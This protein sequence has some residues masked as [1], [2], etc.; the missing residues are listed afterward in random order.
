MNPKASI[1]DCVIPSGRGDV[2]LLLDDWRNG[3]T[4]ALHSLIPMVYEELRRM[5]DYH[6]RGERQC[7]MQPTVLINELY[8]RLNK[9][10]NAGLEDSTQFFR[11]ASTLM[12]RILV[13]DARQRNTKKRGGQSDKITEGQDGFV[14]ADGQTLSPE[15][16]ITLDEALTQLS[17]GKPRAAQVVELRF[18][19]GLQTEE[20]A[21]I[22]GVSRS[23]VMREWRF[24]KQWLA[25]EIKQVQGPHQS[26]VQAMGSGALRKGV[27]A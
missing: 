23:L 1:Y 25:R 27:T 4:E 3:S 10:V 12:R 8:L 24:A 5:A 19:G 22:L 7:T 15:T 9:S 14:L 18:F 17:A 11:F 2:T 6:L 20:V 13:D 16:L 26:P 21:Q